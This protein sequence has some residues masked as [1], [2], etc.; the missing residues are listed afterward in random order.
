M[1]KVVEASGA[2]T[3]T[4]DDFAGLN[5]LAAVGDAAGF[6]QVHHAVAEH[7]RV[8]AQLFVTGQRRQHRIGNV[9]NTLCPG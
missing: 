5:V 2:Q 1:E 8:D 7:F 9:A 6:H 4:A 3:E